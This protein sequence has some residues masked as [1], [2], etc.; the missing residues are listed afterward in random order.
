[1]TDSAV[2]ILPSR[3][4][5]QT[6]TFY[7]RLGFTVRRDHTEPY[8]IARRGDWELHFFYFPD[9]DP[10]TSNHMC[11]LWTAGGKQLWD[12]WLRLGLPAAGIPR[13]QHVGVDVRRGFSEF[14]VIDPNG[15]LLRVGT[16]L[17][18]TT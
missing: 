5:D 10:Y 11:F 4:L 13:L 7:E 3:D 12:D 8:L 2:P 14:A 1:M 6:I 15:T 16:R 17:T 9:L 18:A